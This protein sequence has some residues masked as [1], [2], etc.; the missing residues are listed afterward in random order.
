MR[1]FSLVSMTAL[2]L[3]GACG[4][5][6]TPLDRARSRVDVPLEHVTNP[7]PHT[8]A[9]PASM[10]VQPNSNGNRVVYTVTNKDTQ[11][12]TYFFSASCT[13]SGSCGGTTPTSGTIAAGASLPFA[14]TFSVGSTVSGSVIGHVV[15]GDSTVT[16]LVT[17]PAEGFVTSIRSNRDTASA[18][19][20]ANSDA[21]IGTFFVTNVGS[22]SGTTTLSCATSGPI[23]CT[24]IFTNVMSLKAGSFNK[25]LVKIH[26][27]SPGV[28]YLT[29]SSSPGGGQDMIQ[30]T[31]Q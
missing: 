30:I 31:V 5:P 14:V 24:Q 20:A 7:G 16:T 15:G 26:A 22:D 1:T 12:N 19:V 27:G 10:A 29:I 23:T 18:P 17:E 13:G 6:E 4:Q 3:L 11:T 9:G 21:N 8:I 2:L 25:T 28:A